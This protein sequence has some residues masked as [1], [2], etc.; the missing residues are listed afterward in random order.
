MSDQQVNTIESTTQIT[1]NSE[2]KL[3]EIDKTSITVPNNTPIYAFADI[4][5]DIHLLIIL[6]RDLAKVIRKKTGE[7]DQ[8]KLDP[9]L[10][11]LL[12]LDLNLNEVEYKDDLNY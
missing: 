2:P 3:V 6:L 5:A 9:D 1:T 4:S 7:F 10:E 11:S 8:N 12:L